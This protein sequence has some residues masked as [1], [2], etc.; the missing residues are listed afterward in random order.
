M[1]TGP[2]K[3]V[4]PGTLDYPACSHGTMREAFNA[5]L[6]A[7]DQINT[8][9]CGSWYAAV[10]AAHIYIASY[11]ASLSPDFSARMMLHMDAMQEL[12]KASD[13]QLHAAIE[14]I[15]RPDRH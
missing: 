10:A 5:A 7:F 15:I 13:A 3:Q 6:R 9:D 2:N 4:Q 14:A 8:N 11:L 1:T 12:P